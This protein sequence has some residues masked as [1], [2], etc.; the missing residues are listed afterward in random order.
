ME[1][2]TDSRVQAFLSYKPDENL[3]SNNAKNL[4]QS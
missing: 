3:L 2:L 1:L 4:K